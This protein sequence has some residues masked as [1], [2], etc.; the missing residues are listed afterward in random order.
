M[1]EFLEFLEIQ[2]NKY[3]FVYIFVFAS[4]VIKVR[5]E[6]MLFSPSPYKTGLMHE[7]KIPQVNFFKCSSGQKDSQKKTHNNF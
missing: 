6:G 7:K 4:W 2:Q 5:L 1:P 3:K